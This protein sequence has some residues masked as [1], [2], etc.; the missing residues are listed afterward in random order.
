MTDAR[1]HLTFPE[2]LISEP[3]IHRIGKDFGLVTNI[4]RANIEERHGWVILEM[5]GPD[6][7]IADAV[8]W[9]TTQGVQV[10]RLEG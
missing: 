4:R 1:Y 3:V 10:D 6:A 5:D 7:A 2:H 9:L 8:A